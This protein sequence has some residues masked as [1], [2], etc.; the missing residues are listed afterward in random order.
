MTLFRNVSCVVCMC[1]AAL[2]GQ[3]ELE[4]VQARG[5]G[6]C[7]TRATLGGGLRLLWTRELGC[8]LAALAGQVEGLDCVPTLAIKMETHTHTEMALFSTSNLGERVLLIVV[9]CP[10]GKCSRVSK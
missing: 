10:F 1:Q 9:P 8:M 7:Y 3:G 5:M 4:W 2:A 6:A